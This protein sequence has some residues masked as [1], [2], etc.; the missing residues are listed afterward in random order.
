M[1]RI[2]EKLS[3]L[4]V[5]ADTAIRRAEEA[6]AKNKKL[7]QALL[8]RDQEIKSK[9]HRLDD[10]RK[11]TRTYFARMM[12]IHADYTPETS[13]AEHNERKLQRAEQERDIWEKKYEEAEKKYRKAQADLEEL[14][15]NMDNL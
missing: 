14:V 10:P 8:E 5:E 15:V 13:T 11:G 1:E 4:R 3:N 6:E 2:K 9:D 12:M 7:E